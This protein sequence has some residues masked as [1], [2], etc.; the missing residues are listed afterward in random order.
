MS[1]RRSTAAALLASAPLWATLGGC[2]GQG[3]DATTAPTPT[4]EA[5]LPRQ[6]VF[7]GRLDVIVQ[8][9]LGVVNEEDCTPAHNR[10]CSADGQA[11]VPIT[12]PAPATLVEAR[13]RLA[14]GHTSWTTVLRFDAASR[15]ALTRAA[16]RAG[17][18]GGMVLVMDAD[19]L[20]LAAAPFTLV[21]GRSIVFD[22]LDKPDAWQ[23]V[24]NVL[25]D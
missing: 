25:G 8:P 13:A 17:A 18:A 11:F 2:G 5:P 1:W 19:R 15:A 12:D 23:L 20:V 14:E 6:P 7:T 3:D 16:A 10:A 21:R 9:A 24:E 4:S 22:D